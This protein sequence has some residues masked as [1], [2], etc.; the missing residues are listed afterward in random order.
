[1][2]ELMNE[3]IIVLMDRSKEYSNELMIILLEIKYIYTKMSS[4]MKFS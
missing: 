4:F 1:M 3:T 2:T